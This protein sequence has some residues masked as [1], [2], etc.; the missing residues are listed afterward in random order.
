VGD[1][2]DGLCEGNSVGDD[3]GL[4]DGSVVGLN[5]GRY[6]MKCEIHPILLSETFYTYHF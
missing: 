6:S 4:D 5:D 3:I 1:S 2:V